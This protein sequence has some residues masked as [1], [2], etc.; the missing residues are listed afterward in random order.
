MCLGSAYVAVAVGAASV[1][2]GD[3]KT[4]V[5]VPIATESGVVS[6]EIKGRRIAKLFRVLSEMNVPDS[7]NRPRKEE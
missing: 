2:G 6:R 1:T 5:K 4:K 3:R 7:R